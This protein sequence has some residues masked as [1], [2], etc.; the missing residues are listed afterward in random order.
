M[1]QTQGSGLI[2]K[3]LAATVGVAGLYFV[4]IQLKND[5]HH[6]STHKLDQNQ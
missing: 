2:R 3:V 4:V 5:S 1:N 6:H